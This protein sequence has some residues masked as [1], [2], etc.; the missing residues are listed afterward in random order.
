M[1]F[2]GLAVLSRLQICWFL[3]FFS[4]DNSGKWGIKSK[5]SFMREPYNIESHCFLLLLINYARWICW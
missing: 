1:N 4:A 3:F 5:F 2:G